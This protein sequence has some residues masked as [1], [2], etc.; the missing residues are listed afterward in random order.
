MARCPRLHPLARAPLIDRINEWLDSAWRKGMLSRPPL[1]PEALWRKAHGSV[2]GGSE[3]GGRCE[4]DAADFRLRLEVLTEALVT[5][6][7]LNPL[8]EAVA[9]GQLVRVLCQRLRLG[10]LWERNP[11]LARTKLAPPILVVGQMRAG[12]TRIH[13][14]LAADPAHS[15][16]RF[17]DSWNP[18]PEM[19]DLRVLRSACMLLGARRIDPWIDSIHPFGAGRADE[20]LG[21]LA[22]ALNHCAYEAQWHVP[23]F[24]R[25]SEARDPAPVYREFSRILATDAARHGNARRPRVMKV[26]QFAEDLPALFA[27]FPN[28]RAI[29]THR[30]AR[31]VARSAVSLVA[32]QMTIQ[33]DAVELGWIEQE[34]QRKI[35]L[36]EQRVETGLTDFRGPLAR[37]DFHAFEL[38]WEMAMASIYRRLELDL[39]D[40]AIAA[41]HRE[42][43]RAGASPHVR[44]AEDMRAF[45]S[46]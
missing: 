9:H 20:E 43:R 38:D 12:T 15:S 26:P 39:S 10:R 24:T 13:R 4:E 35:A 19:P 27:Q 31:D 11:R 36:R 1:D 2:R 25:F 6:A 5:E 22:S 28:A 46:A 45:Q 32:N 21:W 30:A 34:W 40:R 8:G 29:V 42:Q 3:T 33:S 18:V 41:M 37:V 17:C 16:T 14:L 23:S 7:R 44:H